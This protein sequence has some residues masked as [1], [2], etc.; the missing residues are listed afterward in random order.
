MEYSRLQKGLH[1]LSAFVIMWLLIAGFY[2]GLVS[3]DAVFKLVITEL[4]VSV[5][6]FLAPVFLFRMCLS[7]GRGYGALHG[8]KNLMPWL[9]FFVHT[10]MYVSVVVV[11]LSGV[12]MMDRPIIFLTLLRSPSLLIA[13]I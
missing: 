1:A 3:K 4:N 5:S 8:V 10:M 12:L 11:L 9:A 7:F 2:A 13:W 6:L